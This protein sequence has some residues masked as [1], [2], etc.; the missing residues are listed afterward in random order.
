MML[1]HQHEYGVWSK[2]APD[3]RAAYHGVDGT[4]GSISVWLSEIPDA[5]RGEQEIIN[6]IPGEKIEY[7]DFEA[8]MG[9]DLQSGLTNLK[10][11]LETTH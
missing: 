8:I 2:T 1:Q 9:N 5:V 4:V 6:I 10:H 11:L 3:M 7:V